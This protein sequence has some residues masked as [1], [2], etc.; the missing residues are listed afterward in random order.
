MR[1]SPMARS[2]KGLMGSNGVG[3]VDRSKKVDYRVFKVF[4]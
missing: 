3:P 1:T 2:F 4:Q